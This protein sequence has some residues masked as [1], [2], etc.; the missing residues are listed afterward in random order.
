VG[1]NSHRNDIAVQGAVVRCRSRRL[2]GEVARLAG[3]IAAPEDRVAVVLE[4]LAE[5]NTVRAGRLLAQ[6]GEARRFAEHERREQERRRRVC[7]KL[8]WAEFS[9]AIDDEM[10]GMVRSV[11]ASPNRR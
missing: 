5:D 11:V 9:E 6:A 2:P 8:R 7:A 1:T 3:A 4:R 10:P